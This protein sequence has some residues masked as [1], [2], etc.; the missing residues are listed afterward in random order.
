MV[1]RYWDISC[2]NQTNVPE[3]CVRLLKKSNI[4]DNHIFLPI[5]HFVRCFFFSKA[6]KSSLTNWSVTNCYYIYSKS[7][8]LERIRDFHVYNFHKWQLELLFIVCFLLELKKW[9][10]LMNSSYFIVRF[11]SVSR[12]SIVFSPVKIVFAVHLSFF[13]KALF[14]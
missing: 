3:K 14:I 12:N 8:V 5:Y 11:M 1:K 2:S 13:V 4:T 6:V 7:K 10:S 9:Y